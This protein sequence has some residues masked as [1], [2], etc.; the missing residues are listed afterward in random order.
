MSK[1]LERLKS[2]AFVSAVS[3][4]SQEI[5]G[6]DLAP[7]RETIF[8]E[9][10][11]NGTDK[12]CQKGSGELLS[13]SVSAI[14]RGTPKI[15]RPEPNPERV[16]VRPSEL[17]ERIEREPAI[18]SRTPAI[19]G[20]VQALPDHLAPLIRAASSDALPTGTVRLDGGLVSDLKAFTL[21]WSAAFLI[22]DRAHA[23][24]RLE[25]ANRAWARER[26]VN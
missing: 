4:E 15:T 17:L 14:P 10:T 11:Q 5:G 16:F 13:V 19:G 20:E 12:S 1:W 22:G 6:V 7:P 8:S 23:L 2:S 26:G 3:E 9:D 21:A 24:E 18:L 25:A